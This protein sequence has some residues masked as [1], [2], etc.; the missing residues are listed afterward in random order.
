MIERFSLDGPTR[1]LSGETNTY[2]VGRE[3]GLVIDPAGQRPDLDSAIE[4]GVGH[5]AVTH[6]HPDHVDAVR[7]YARKYDL[8]VWALAGRAA[9]FESATG[10]SPDRTFHP[11]TTIPAA[12]GVEV[13]DTPGHAPEHVSFVTRDGTVTGDLVLGEGSVVVG[14]PEGDMR[15]Y[16]SSLRRVYARDPDRL[17]PGHGPVIEDPRPTCERLLDHRLDREKRV[18]EAIRAGAETPDEIV[19]AAYDKD[20]SAVY[21]LARATVIAHVEKLAVE[22][23]VTFDGKRAVGPDF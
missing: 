23:K 22:G 4:R 2:V 5:L 17:Y 1:A 19:D 20:V 6:H 16:I 14:A 7:T 8:T 10:I 21:D 11:E 9:A 18:H 13:L 15:A 12:G 3:N